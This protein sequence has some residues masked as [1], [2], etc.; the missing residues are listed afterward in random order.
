[1]KRLIILFM[2]LFASM[3][4]LYAQS[5]SGIWVG[6]I[7][8]LSNANVS[9]QSRLT[10][11][12]NGVKFTGEYLVELNGKTDKYLV[13]GSLDENKATGLATFPDDGSVFQ[14]EAVLKNEQLLIVIGQAGIPTLAGTLSRESSRTQASI[15]QNNNYPPAS[16]GVTRDPRLL[17]TWCW[18][19]M[20]PAF[21]NYSY[22]TFRNDGS[23]D[24]YLNS[25]STLSSD[26]SISRQPVEEIEYLKRNS[27]LWF[28]E[29]ST[30][31]FKYPNGNIVRNIKYTMDNGV[32]TWRIISSGE[33]RRYKR[34]N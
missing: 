20:D 27:G 4:C 24:G 15:R 19:S 18:E 9:I 16:P 28:T 33:V 8:Y 31:C 11:R 17:G 14:I 21:I 5:L 13:Q 26:I 12:G 29:N 6:Q 3:C 32:M 23:I 7:S 22:W 25:S 10:I 34:V 2:L 30:L 1:M